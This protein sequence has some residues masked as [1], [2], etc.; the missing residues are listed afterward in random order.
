[1]LG[2][3]IFLEE[4]LEIVEGSSINIR[5]NDSMNRVV[6]IDTVARKKFFKENEDVIGEIIDLMII[7]I[8]LLVFMNHQ[9]PS[10]SY[11]EN[12]ECSCQ[13]LLFR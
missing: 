10:N 11:R 1:M 13:D 8:R 4:I 5:D 12:G 7:H 2:Q 3:I 9:F 6:M